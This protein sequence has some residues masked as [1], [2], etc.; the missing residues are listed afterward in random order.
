[1]ARDSVR[2]T[3]ASGAPPEKSRARP[4]RSRRSEHVATKLGAERTATRTRFLR[5]FS[6]VLRI[7]IAVVA[8]AAAVAVARSVAFPIGRDLEVTLETRRKADRSS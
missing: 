3:T 2:G 6:R 4:R 7:A 5:Y 8:A 1:M